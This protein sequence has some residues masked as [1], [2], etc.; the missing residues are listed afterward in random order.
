MTIIKL[1]IAVNRMLL[2]ILITASC[3]PNGVFAQSKPVKFWDNVQV[4]SSDTDFRYLSVD[5]ERVRDLFDTKESIVIPTFDDEVILEIKRTSYFRASKTFFADKKNSLKSATISYSDGFVTGTIVDEDGDKFVLGHSREHGYNFIRKVNPDEIMECG[6][7]DSTVTLLK[8]GH[9]HLQNSTVS[10]FAYYQNF[11]TDDTVTVDIAIIYSQDAENWASNS[12][13][14]VDI[15]SVINTIDQK[16][17]AVLKNSELKIK[18][19]IVHTQ[20]VS[21]P[22]STNSTSQ[23][24]SLM[25]FNNY[26]DIDL[27]DM[28]KQYG[29]DIVVLLDE[30]N[31]TGGI[32][33]IPLYYGGS[34]YSGYNIVRIQQ[35]HTSQTTAHEI[36]HNFGNAHGRTQQ[37]N[38][39]GPAG[40]VLPFST[41]HWLQGDDDYVTVMHYNG[42][43]NGTA[44][45]GIDHFSN[46]NVEF[47]GIP[48]GTYSGEGGPSDNAFSMEITKQWIAGYTVTQIDAPIISSSAADVTSE[49]VQAQRDDQ[50][51]TIFN[52]GDSPLNWAA[53]AFINGA[54]GNNLIN[55]DTVFNVGFEAD[56]GFEASTS[57]IVKDWKSFDD[58]ET[59]SVI[60]TDPGEG[61]QSLRIPERQSQFIYSGFIN[62]RE[63]GIYTLK[64][65]IK[66]ENTNG[67]YFISVASDSGIS[68][69]ISTRGDGFIGMYG[70]Y[71]ALNS[72]WTFFDEEMAY[73]RDE[74]LDVEIRMSPENGGTNTYFINGNFRIFENSGHHLPKQIRISSSSNGF[75]DLVI[76]DIAL[77]NEDPFG[78]GLH[79]QNLNGVIEPGGTSLIDLALTALDLPEDIYNGSL[80][81]TS[82]DPNNPVLNIPINLTV[83][84]ALETVS[85]TFAFDVHG[86]NGWR[87]FSSPVEGATYDDLFNQLWTQG[88]TGADRED[89]P[90]NIYIYDNETAAFSPPDS[91]LQTIQPGQ[92]FIAYI[93]AD[94][95]EPGPDQTF[96]KTIEINGDQHGVTEVGFNSEPFGFSLIGNP[97]GSSIDLNL[98]QS[99]GIE[100]VFYTYR[101]SDDTYISWN[102]LAGGISDGI[103]APFQGFWVQASDAGTSNITFP[104]E[105]K[106]SGG[107][108][109]KKKEQSSPLIAI[110]AEND[111]LRNTAWFS[112]SEH[113]SVARDRKDAIKLQPLDIV[114]Y[115]T[116]ASKS[117]G[118]LLDINNLPMD[119]N[120]E[121][122]IPLN[123]QSF[124]ATGDG[125][126]QKGGEFTLTWPNLE[127]IPDHWKVILTDTKS[128]TK[129]DLKIESLYSFELESKKIKKHRSDDSLINKQLSTTDQTRFMLT[130]GGVSTELVNGLSIPRDFRLGQNY[131]N[132]FNPSTTIEFDLPIQSS[133]RLAIY[134]IMGQEIAVLVDE[135]RVAGSHSVSWDASKIASGL[136]L[137]RLHAGNKTIDRKMILLK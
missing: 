28:R 93:Y 5:S 80:V 8:K 84:N 36:G 65:K 120:E 24:L 83:N 71:N 4:K 40:G 16:N 31:D 26:P 136:Y 30:F 43:Q 89:G 7:K 117:N 124:E 60:T 46:P 41:G 135:V 69:G 126:V 6:V 87:M 85:G 76:D 91:Q 47:N 49:I 35:A 29:A 82:N 128:D 50:S 70:N 137:Y 96:P 114:D 86:K 54:S 105:A 109:Q 32:G 48:T 134:N 57:S 33:S 113:G 99:E 94:D 18:W 58:S 56:E 79:V 110:R 34:F 101:S 103:V 72:F 14:V 38:A 67:T 23:N 125:W 131:P 115:V 52:N 130:I 77:I 44:A 75:A 116:I 17:Q 63:E 3:L 90:P 22:P 1:K 102:G 59:F 55:A 45:P 37:S 95:D 61:Q 64:F 108:F 19:R 9:L 106:V 53:N 119:L 25:S 92:G 74:W 132:P 111:G 122:E 133:V 112:F 2:C 12:E 73:T 107:I 11:T 13:D 62:T 27:V 10:N 129:I 21:N 104:N 42:L 100:D 98:L 78:A 127:D 68:A 88:F 97:Y 20:L 81:I 15:E 121:L 51:I 39:A 118:N 66:I 123:I